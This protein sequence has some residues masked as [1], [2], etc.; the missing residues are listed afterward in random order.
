MALNNDNVED[1]FILLG[2]LGI[3]DMMN[4]EQIQIKR[5]C[6]PTEASSHLAGLI[7]ESTETYGLT[8]MSAAVKTF[9]KYGKA[10]M[11]VECWENSGSKNKQIEKM[12]YAMR[13]IDTGLSLCSINDLVKGIATLRELF[14]QGFDVSADDPVARLFVLMSEGVKKDYGALV[15]S[16]EAGFIELIKWAFSKGFYQACLTLIEAKAPGNFVPRGMLY[17]CN[18]ESQKDHVTELFARKRMQMKSY[19]YWKMNDIDHYFI[20]NYFLY[21]FPNNTMERPRENGKQMVACIDNTNP[22]YITGYTACNDRQALED[23]MFS[24]MRIG[25][26]RNKTN[27]AEETEEEEFT[28]FPDEKEESSKLREITEAIQFFIQSFDKVSENISGK[29]P[30]VVRITS[31]EVKR[32]AQRLEEKEKA[33]RKKNQN[34]KIP[35]ADIQKPAA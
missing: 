13:R 10:D 5:I 11:I 4:G 28:L 9:L 12:I 6:T 33:E 14:S 3:L 8:S 30:V 24:Y 19:E 31:D 35:D 2:V 32:M 23:L 21:K 17:Y 34:E 27:H 25:T 20:K 1:N 29:N 18:D 7:Q 26:I 22:D 16:E 15:T